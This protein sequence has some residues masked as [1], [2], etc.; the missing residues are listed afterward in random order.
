[1]VRD[2]GWFWKGDLLAAG[3]VL[4]LSLS[5]GCMSVFKL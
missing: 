5:A 4:F 3:Q 2:E 1:M